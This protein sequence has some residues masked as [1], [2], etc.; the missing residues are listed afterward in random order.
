MKRFL[1]GD[2]VRVRSTAVDTH[3]RT[4]AYVKGKTGKVQAMSGS[5][6][7]P[8]HRA[9]GDSGLPKRDLYLVA[10]KMEDLW[11][12]NYPGPHADRLVLDIYEHWLDP[13]GTA[14]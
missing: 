1:P 2:R 5:F 6:Y 7:D 11:G 3:H 14:G 8:E 4:P 12:K 9:Y 10:F 13:V